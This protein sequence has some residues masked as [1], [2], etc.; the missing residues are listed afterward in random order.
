[1]DRCDNRLSARGNLRNETYK[2]P[3]VSM[4]SRW[5]ATVLRSREKNGDTESNEERKREQCNTE[6]KDRAYGVQVL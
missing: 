2:R 6:R 4:S 1:M 5:L 3:V